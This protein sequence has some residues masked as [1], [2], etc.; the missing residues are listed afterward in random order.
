MARWPRIVPPYED[1]GASL[2]SNV[3]ALLA[4][5]PSYGWR[6]PGVRRHQPLV[7]E[8][9]GDT[10]AGQRVVQPVFTRN[11]LANTAMSSAVPV[12]RARHRYPMPS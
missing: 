12:V 10:S 4:Q 8:T 1:Q 6:F 9:S 2:T 7:N 3:K 11:C 5:R